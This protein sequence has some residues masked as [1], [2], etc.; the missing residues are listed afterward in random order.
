MVTLAIQTSRRSSA[1]QPELSRDMPKY[2]KVSVAASMAGLVGLHVYMDTY[3]GMH[4]YQVSSKP[5][6]GPGR[7]RQAGRQAGRHHYQDDG[8]IN[9]S[10]TRVPQV[11]GNILDAIE[12]CF[13]AAYATR[14]ARQNRHPFF[15]V[16]GRDHGNEKK[17]KP[18]FPLRYS[19]IASAPSTIPSLPGKN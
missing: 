9:I 17:E 10:S 3:G 15:N 1:G 16:R 6:G 11:R 18:N 7:E 12:N 4:Q 14:Y 5:T 13:A 2:L 8:P 19:N